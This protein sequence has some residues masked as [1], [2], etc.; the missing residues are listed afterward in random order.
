[1]GSDSGRTAPGETIEDSVV[2]VRMFENQ[3]FKQSHR[4]LSGVKPVL[5]VTYGIIINAIVVLR[6]KYRLPF[7]H[8][9]DSYLSGIREVVRFAI[10]RDRICFHPFDE[11]EL[12]KV[13]ELKVVF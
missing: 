9:R 5:V 4:F 6:I 8:T 13:R 11:T 10:Q 2:L 12:F 7:F 3:V 1:M